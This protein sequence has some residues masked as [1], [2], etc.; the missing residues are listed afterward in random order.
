MPCNLQ[1]ARAQVTPLEF[2]P[3]VMGPYAGWPSVVVPMGFSTPSEAAPKG[4][5]LG[6]DI[7]GPNKSFPA[8]LETAVLFQDRLV[9]VTNPPGVPLTSPMPRLYNLQYCTP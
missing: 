2:G 8:M 9:L 7:V 6:L 3:T 5:P 4:L 1:P